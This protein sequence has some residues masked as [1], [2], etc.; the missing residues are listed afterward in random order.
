MSIIEDVNKL[1][2]SLRIIAVN[3]FLIPFWYIS[4]YLFNNDLYKSLDYILIFAICIV[5]SISSSLP[6]GDMMNKAE[7]ESKDYVESLEN[8]FAM[9][10]SS[11]ITLCIWLS[12]LIFVT[13][14]LKFLYN[15]TFDFYY[16]VVIY[17]IP[18]VT[19]WL[20]YNLEVY[21]LKKNILG[22]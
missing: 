2:V 11:I 13:Y 10:L 6:L 7:K 9:T 19:L 16:F 3:I 8:Y 18:I 4:I 15:F 5:F 14:S 22:K 1:S 20:F 12:I 21:L 17:Y